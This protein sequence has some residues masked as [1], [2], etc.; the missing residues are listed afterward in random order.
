VLVELM[1]V[2]TL[3]PFVPLFGASPARRSISR[4]APARGG[5]PA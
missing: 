1:V 4:E 3:L 2:A 5:S